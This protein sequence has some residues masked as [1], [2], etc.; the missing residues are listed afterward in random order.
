MIDGMPE[1]KREEVAKIIL[2]L[3]KS[4][5]NMINIKSMFSE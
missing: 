1:T 4:E 2:V 3:I 5:W